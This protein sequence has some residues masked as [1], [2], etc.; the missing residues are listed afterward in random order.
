[1][2]SR[3]VRENIDLVEDDVPAEESF[4]WDATNPKVFLTRCDNPTPRKGI[5]DPHS[6]RHCGIEVNAVPPQNIKDWLSSW[7]RTR[8]AK[9]IYIVN[10]WYAPCV[11][12][13][14]DVPQWIEQLASEAK[15]CFFTLRSKTYHQNHPTRAITDEEH[16]WVNDLE[17]PDRYL[18]THSMNLNREYVHNSDGSY[19]MIE[20][21]QG[22]HGNA[23]VKDHEERPSIK[24][25]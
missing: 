13:I 25:S 12:D 1:M 19:K 17:D 8:H 24:T 16:N 21:T 7:V 23:E 4:N 10:S 20:R 11:F 3:W 9:K 6:I 14:P 15:N 5:P 2:K 22:Q 18:Y